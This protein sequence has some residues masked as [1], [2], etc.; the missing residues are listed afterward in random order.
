VT[1]RRYLS[2]ALPFR[3]AVTSNSLYYL[4]V[5]K[6]VY[7]TQKSSKSTI[8]GKLNC[9]NDEGMKVLIVD[10]NQ[11]VLNALEQFLRSNFE[12]STIILVQDV[13]AALEY[14]EQID[15]DICLIDYRLKDNDGLT[16][17]FKIRQMLPKTALVII[18]GFEE[19]AGLLEKPFDAWINK[20]EGNKKLL[21]FIKNIQLQKI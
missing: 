11:Q 21:D 3:E 2:V 14:C 8:P 15:F 20:T 5:R 16:L 9:I 7:L 17:S 18:S 12:M 13:S 4:S 19:P 6:A 10:D 1:L